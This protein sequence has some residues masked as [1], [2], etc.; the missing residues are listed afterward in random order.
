MIPGV[1]AALFQAADR[2]GYCKLR[3]A[4]TEIKSTIFGHAEFTS[5]NASAN[6]LFANWSATNAMRLK[7]IAQGVHPKALIETIAEDL[8]AAFEHAPLL[9]PYDIYQHLRD[10]WAETMQD[11][12]YL[13]AGDGWRE[14]AQPRLLVDDKAKKTKAKPDLT[15]GKKKYQAELIPPALVIARY[16]AKAQAEVE[17]LEAQVADFQ[18]QMEEMAE[19]HGGEDGL[20]EEAK[21]DKGKL[22]RASAASRTKE[23][24]TDSDAADE[25][26]LLKDYLDLSES[27]SAASATLNVAQ[28]SLIERVAAKYGQLTEDEI[29]T[30]V[31]DGKWMATLAAAM[32]SELARVSQTLTGRIR[33]LAERY[34]TPLPQLTAEVAALATRVEARLQQMGCTP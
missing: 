12:C 25:L 26:K 29:K 33:Q 1:R 9:D 17:A 10:Y 21:N 7:G 22:T 4:A 8:L 27:E 13:I 15:L 28:N 6:T 31:V 3:V 5:F 23:I 32:Q 11:D 16:Y 18:Q 14:A 2:P 20:L 24:K 30:L 19:E 34:A